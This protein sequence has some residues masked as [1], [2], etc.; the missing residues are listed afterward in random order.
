MMPQEEIY[1]DKKNRYHYW[2]GS[3]AADTQDRI[4]EKCKANAVLNS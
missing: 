1:Y 2:N 3:I 4:G